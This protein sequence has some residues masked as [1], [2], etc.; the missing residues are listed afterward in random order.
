MTLQQRCLGID[1]GAK[2][3]G[4]AVSDPLN[5]I[6]QGLTTVINSK[7]TI[8][9]LVKVIKQY[10]VG[11]VVVG[12]PLNLKGEKACKVEEVERFTNELEQNIACS[13]IRW[14][15]RF[16]TKRALQSL[17]EMGVKR[18]RR[19]SKATLDQISAALILQSYLDNRNEYLRH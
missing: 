10:N 6:A 5:I 2:R 16:T 12:L 7:N 15:E 11:T 19:Q 8:N 4:I 18:K 9:E 17:A 14:D 1:Y 13:V 3:I